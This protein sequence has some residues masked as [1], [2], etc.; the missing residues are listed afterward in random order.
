MKGEASRSRSTASRDDE[1]PSAAREGRGCVRP[2]AV[3][4]NNSENNAAPAA[5][6]V[7]SPVFRSFET[8]E[9]TE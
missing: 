9:A 5:D 6:E 4:A 7:E 2:S 8:R 3:G 1:R